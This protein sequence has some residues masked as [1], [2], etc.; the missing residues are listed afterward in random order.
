[1]ETKLIGI[2]K[3]TNAEKKNGAEVVFTRQTSDREFTIYACK[4]YESWEQWGA[5]IEVLGDN[6]D[7][8][9]KWRREQDEEEIID[10]SYNWAKE[11]RFSY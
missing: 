4:S 2:R 6:V 11:H 1:M 7:D 3:P 5:P 8:V 9:E 10:D